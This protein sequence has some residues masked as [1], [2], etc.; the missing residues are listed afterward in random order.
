MNL[1][2]SWSYSTIHPA[3]DCLS[4]GHTAPAKM[5][6]KASIR[7]LFSRCR[8]AE[9]LPHLV[10]STSGGQP[11]AA[12]A[13][14][15]QAPTPAS[16]SW[17]E[18]WPAKLSAERTAELR[19]RFEE[20]YP[21][22]LLDSEVFPSSRLLALTSQ[23]VAEKEIRWL[24][25]RFRLSAKAQDENLMIRPKKL[26]RLQELSDLLLDEAPTRDIH[27]GPAS[28]NMINQLLTL[29]TNSIALC[30]GAHLSAKAQDENLMIRPKKLPRL[31]ELSDLLLDEAPTRDIHDGPASYNMINQ[32]LTLAT[33]SIALCQ[34]AHL[35]ALKMYQKRFLRLCFT[36]YESASNLRGPTSLEAQSADKRAWEIIAELV[37][38]HAWKLDDA[39]HEMSEVRADL[40][41]L[42]APRAT[43]P[44]Q[45]LNHQ[46]TWRPRY[47]GRGRGGK[48][49]GKSGKSKEDSRFAGGDRTERGG[50]GGKSGGKGKDVVACV[51][52]LLWATHISR[53]L[54]PYIAPLYKLLNSPPGSNV[55]IA[56]RM[57]PA[58]LHCLD[59]CAVVCREVSGLHLPI[60]SRIIE[61]GSK[62]VHCKAD[63]PSM[64]KF[65]GPTWVRLSDPTC[66]QTKVTNAAQNSLHWLL[67]LIQAIPTT[68]LSLPPVL[69]CLARADAMAEGDKV[70]I[71]G[72]I[73]TKHI[74]AWFAEEYNM[75]EV[76]QFWP[77]L[78][79]DAHR[80]IACFETLAQQ[81][82]LAMSARERPATSHLCICL[83][84]ESEN[85]PTEAGINKLFSTRPVGRAQPFSA[86][87]HP[88]HPVMQSSCRYHHM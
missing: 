84:S 73:T 9:N 78:S 61:V 60:K 72:W 39:L 15:A 52:L 47:P 7:L 45:L 63:L 80:Y 81:L 26:P 10:G 68:S 49:G 19:R 22:E 21:T 46:E 88:G 5:L 23:M 29:A 4:R 51:G 28:Y 20:D 40:S 31:Q 8:T 50:K 56:P 75:R 53:V 14:A 65:A 6:A 48:A 70:G 42:L 37:N 41:S 36:K 32:L 17:Q 86:C 87:L 1:Q 27:D 2:M 24:P 58:F 30:Q 76:R 18:A 33:N 3:C 59:S 66:L 34:G 12:T 77:F 11:A 85:M 69:S 13:P 25:W 62:P 38:Q 54:R 57:W 35:G 43:L 16:T 79:K 44:K 83:P 74:L 64:P 55:S 71:G 82:A 67:P